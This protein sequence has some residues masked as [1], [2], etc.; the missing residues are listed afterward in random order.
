VNAGPELNVGS[1]TATERTRP[2]R[3]ASASSRASASTRSAG[4]MAVRRPPSAPG[5]SP[6]CWQN[7]QVK[8]QPRAVSQRMKGHS[9]ALP[10]KMGDGSAERS[11]RLTRPSS[12][13]AR[14][15]T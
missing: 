11:A 15:G 5:A 3:A 7:V 2:S 13:P 4:A 8:G 9:A 14:A 6:R 10:S 1:T 12:A